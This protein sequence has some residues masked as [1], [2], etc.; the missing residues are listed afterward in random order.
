M[1]SNRATQMAIR[2]MVVRCKTGKSPRIRWYT[3][4]LFFIFSW[5]I[6]LNFLLTHLRRVHISEAAYQCLNGVYEVDPGNGQE[7]D[8]YLREHDVQTYLIKQV[9]PMRTRR[10]LASRPR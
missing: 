6:N 1:R 3:R 8:A 10:R 7:R 9:E 5:P 4:V 2:Y